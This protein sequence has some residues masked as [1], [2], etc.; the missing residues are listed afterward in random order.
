MQK[1]LLAAGLAALALVACSESPTAVPT[2][3]ETSLSA[4]SG[5]PDVAGRFIITLRERTN[6]AAV[7]RDHGVG[8]DYLYTHALAGFAGRVSDA[9]RRG[10]L[11]DNRV[12]R[13][14]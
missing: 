9:A 14:E 7:A 5:P 8:P 10:L 11:R 12:V 2:E 4:G 6:P 1:N 13:V 3:T